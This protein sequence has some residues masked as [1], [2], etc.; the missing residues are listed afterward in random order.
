[1]AVGVLALYFY[2][3]MALKSIEERREWNE[4]L[5]KMLDRYDARLISAVDATSKVT[6]EMHALRGKVSEFMLSME[7]RLAAMDNRLRGSGGND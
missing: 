2:N 6:S 1:V 3:Q 7:S 4:A 5:Q